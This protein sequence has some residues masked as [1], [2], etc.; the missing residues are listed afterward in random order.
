MNH[1][2]NDHNTKST[3]CY[4][5]VK[6]KSEPENNYT[7]VYLNYCEK[8]YKNVLLSLPFN[9]NMIP[10]QSNKSTYSMSQNK[11]PPSEKKYYKYFSLFQNYFSF[12][13]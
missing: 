1:G 12:I 2:R 10:K 7:L 13:T 6:T 8:R 4:Q 11:V 3:G 9:N 5:A